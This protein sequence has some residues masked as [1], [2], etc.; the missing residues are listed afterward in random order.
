MAERMER[1]TGEGEKLVSKSLHIHTMNNKRATKRQQLLHR[2]VINY[3]HARDIRKCRT[4]HATPTCRYLSYNANLPP[5]VYS[6]ERIPGKGRG[7]RRWSLSPPHS[8]FLLLPLFLAR[9]HHLDRDDEYVPCM[10]WTL[11]LSLTL[12][13]PTNSCALAA[14]PG[15][16]QLFEPNV[17]DTNR[18]IRSF[19][20]LRKPAR[21]SSPQCRQTLRG[22]SRS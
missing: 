12:T 16:R 6:T 13:N 15:D 21:S 5:A 7:G 22:S 2:C 1:D 8:L 14:P 4:S 19:I 17:T 9:R 18:H 10:W 20:L 3:N 11:T